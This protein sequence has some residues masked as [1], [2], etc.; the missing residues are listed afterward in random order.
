VATVTLPSSGARAP[1]PAPHI[2]EAETYGVAIAPPL[3]CGFDVVAVT[4]RLTWELIVPPSV[5]LVSWERNVT[6]L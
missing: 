3:P 4:T 1:R 2:S 6:A 5:M